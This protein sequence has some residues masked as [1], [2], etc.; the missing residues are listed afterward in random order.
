MKEKII[1]I[2]FLIIIY[3]F[4]IL[5]L[6][7]DDK[8]VSIYERRKLTNVT[9]LKEDFNE[10]LDSYLTDQFPFREQ[11]LNL[12]SSFNR[13][14]LNNQGFNDVYLKGNYI[15]EKNY[16]LD[17]KSLNNFT[18]K[19]NTINTNFLSNSN[20]YYGIIP[21]KSYYLNDNKYLT[22][23]YDYLY[24]YL[25]NNLN[26]SYIDVENSFDLEDYYKTDIHIK[27]TSYPKLIQ[28][29]SQ[30]FDFEIKNIEY[31]ENIYNEFKGASF[32]KVPFMNTEPLVYL[33]T[34]LFDDVNVKHLEYEDN[35]I[36]KES[37]LN[38]VDSY[39]VFLS[40]PS[41]LIE[42]E[43][44]ALDSDKELIIFR[45]SFGSSLAPLLIPYYK[46]ITL[47]D[48]RYISMKLAQEYVDFKNK[49]V[50]FLYSTLIVNSSYILK[51]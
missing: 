28:K 43:N 11:V 39:N 22:M 13:F 29:L 4:A 9:A 34:D 48:L 36:Y 25:K 17:E 51:E 20:V 31:K 16:P 3:V 2:L 45:D 32:Y 6:V 18:R 44:N 15:I 40:G 26:I 23:D 24:N 33:T 7:F 10:N 41:S 38:S 50:L 37:D 35:F 8:K 42:I 30:Y 5:N 1:I 21:D 46:K 12:N 27:Q 49:D 19:I 47:I 14:V